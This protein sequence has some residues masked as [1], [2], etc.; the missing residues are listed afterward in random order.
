LMRLVPVA[1]RLM[2]FVVGP[3]KRHQHV[4]ISSR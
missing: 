4:D 2:L 3:Q 1:G